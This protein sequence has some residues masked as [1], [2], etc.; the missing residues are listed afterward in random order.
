MSN[1][2]FVL[3]TQLKPLTPCSPGTARRLLKARKAAI[4]R[5]FPFTIVLKKTVEETPQPC[6]LK[7]DPG[8]QTTGL[9]ILQENRVIWAAE[10]AH[11]GRAIK[12]ALLSRRQLRRS[13]RNRKTR[14]RKPRFLNRTRQ[15]GWLPPSLESRISNVLTWVNRLRKVGPV[16]SISQELVRFDTQK[17]QNPEMSG[18][19]YQQGEL[20]GY[21]VREYLLEKWGRK[22]AYCGAENTPLEVEHIVPRSKGGSDRVSNLT[23]ACHKCN[24]AK[25]NQDI[26]DFLSGKPSVLARVLKQA[27][28][29]LKD[30]AAVNATRW[31]LYRRLKET[32]LPVETG[33]GG[34]T[35]YNR[36]R[37]D[38]PKTHWLDAACVGRSTP[39]NLVVEVSKPLPIQ[40]TGQGNRQR[41]L[42][43]KY[44]FARGHRPR[45]KQFFGFQTGDIVKASVTNGKYAG[46]HTGRVAVR[47]RPSFRLNAFDVHPKYLQTLH[48]ADGYEY[49]I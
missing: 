24:Q 43:N 7:I 35:K 3:D 26:R 10:L 20:F 32:G 28:A 15:P 33:T 49:T 12:D 27:K 4:Y 22:C 39:E 25:G 41:V 1:F 23:L 21:E 14:Y 8:S 34:T 42:P 30:A 46:I 45:Q 6:Q 9:A 11:R 40:A 18:I 17:L 38:L 29:P 31:A 16:A 2:V 37:L 36:T 44:G 19:E 5:R 13:R 47:S 48:K